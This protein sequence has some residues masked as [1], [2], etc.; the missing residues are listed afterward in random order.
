MALLH[1]AQH[2]LQALA[3]AFALGFDQLLLRFRVERQEI[4]GRHGIHH[5]L[6][7]KADFL[8]LVRRGI[9]GFRHRNQEFR[10]QQV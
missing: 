1:V 10:V 2:I 6:H 4:G 3:Q 7:G 8:L 9:D 5:L